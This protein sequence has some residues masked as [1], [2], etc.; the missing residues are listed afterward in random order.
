VGLTTIPPSCA[1][2]LDIWVSLSLLEPSWPVQAC[3]GVALSFYNT[4]I[5]EEKNLTRTEIQSPNHPVRDLATLPTELPRSLHY[6]I[7]EIF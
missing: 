6:N 4:L 3:N 5:V 2:C 1:D 7:R